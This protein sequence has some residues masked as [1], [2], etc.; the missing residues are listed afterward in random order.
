[1]EIDVFVSH[2]TSSSLHI[3][4]GIVN[5][6]ESVG[7]RCW[8]APRDTEGTYAS[9]IA[10]A[11]NSCQVFLLI[12]NKPAS[13]SFHVLNEIDMV[14]KRLTKGESVNI[15]PFHVADDEIGEDA[16]YYLGRLHWIDAMTPP[17]YQRIDEL[18]ERIAKILGKEIAITQEK[19]GDGGNT[20]K[21]VSK[22]PQARDIFDGR[23][24][25]LDQIHAAFAEGKRTLFLE[26]I[27]GIGKSELAKQ[28]ALRYREDYDNILFV[29]YELS[30]EKLVCDSTAIEIENFPPIQEEDEHTYF[31]K[32]MQALRSIADERTLI[33]VDN[34]DVD[35]DPNL[36]E[37]L[38]GKYR[39]IFTTRNAHPGYT[40]VKVGT[41][42]DKDVLFRI[43]EQNYGASIE[44]WERPYVEELFERIEYHTYTIELIAKQM[45]AS[46]LNTQEMLELLKKGELQQKVSE[47]VSGR[48]DQKTAFGHICSVFN[49]SNLNEEEQ[50][51]LMFLS[52]M[53]T[54]GIIAPRFKEWANLQS[55]ETVNQLVRKS[56]IRKEGGQRISVHPLVK[57][58]IYA[59]LRPTVDSCL[60]L[61]ESMAVFSFGAWFRNYQE[62]EAVAD[63]YLAVLEYFQN[64][65]GKNPTRFETFCSFLWQVGKF[66]DSI[67]FGHLLY[68]ACV[69]VYGEASLE[70]GFTAKSL[71]GDY[72]NSGRVRES[73]PWYKK[74][75]ESMLESGMIPTEDLAIAYE[76]VAR[77]YTWEYEQ[78]FEKAEEYFQKSLDIRLELREALKAGENRGM[79]MKYE[80]YGP[81]LAEL[82]IGECYMELG[83]MYQMMGDYEKGIEYARKQKEIL[84]TYDPDNLSSIAYDEYD[85]GVCH[86][87]L[88]IRGS[89]AGDMESADAHWKEAEK[90]LSSALEKNM[91]RRGALAIDTI[92]N[93]EYLADV[94]AAMKRYAEA[95]NGYMAVITMTENLM[96]KECERIQS[97]KKKMDFQA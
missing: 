38:E 15:L 21:L 40:T 7:I 2:H 42:Q 70:A 89:E 44:E 76:K 94:Y 49:T 33:I 30:L 43:F 23:D 83:R 9:S 88:G 79:F 17:M 61:L 86:Y 91:E 19:S 58:V 4:E 80:H 18:V 63:N 74:G 73:I 28:Y 57:E 14:T 12:L 37:F 64:D 77:C 8:Y 68:D 59:V 13:E 52:L 53:G 60:E 25:L 95:S 22:M 27:G 54:R 31:Q 36:K 97:V 39:V 45:E 35:M 66:S 20:Y 78:N 67:R 3:V 65:L 92:D 55:F 84:L 85:E 56:W 47:T 34:F 26:G 75:L 24:F 11:L 46:F 69:K 71:G 87:Y 90:C 51:I 48:K 82:R 5:K 41:I 1:M 10:K 93:Q 16:Q 32:K 6:L 62:N 50:R 81:K 96:G 29:T 72:F